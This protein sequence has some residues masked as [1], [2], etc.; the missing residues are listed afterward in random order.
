MLLPKAYTDLQ[1]A[2]FYRELL[3]AK[4]DIDALQRFRERARAAQEL[5]LKDSLGGAKAALAAAGRLL[6]ELDPDDQSRRPF[7]DLGAALMEL[8]QG[9]EPAL[10]RKHVTGH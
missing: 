8:E 2:E 6:V 3:R 9:R 10:L 5:Y 7:V 4:H 1:K